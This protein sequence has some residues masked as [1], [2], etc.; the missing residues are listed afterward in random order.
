[1]LGQG[2]H[3]RNNGPQFQVT[4]TDVTR[5]EKYSIT[6]AVP[7]AN[8]SS[9]EWIAEAPATSQGI[10]PLANFNTVAFSSATATMAGHALQ[11]LGSFGTN[12]QELTMVSQANGNPSKAQPSAV[13]NGTGFSVAWLSPG[14]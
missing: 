13:S 10:L 4:I 7:G 8:M 5:S 1:Y 2:G 11:A 6:S 3:G 9:V 12:I 14:P